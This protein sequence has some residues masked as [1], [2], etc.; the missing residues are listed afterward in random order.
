MERL[1]KRIGNSVAYSYF[2]SNHSDGC[3][4][5]MDNCLQ[6]LADYED[7]EEQGLLIELKIPFGTKIY[8]V[9]EQSTDVEEYVVIGI[10]GTRY[11]VEEPKCI[12][13]NVDYLCS[14]SDS[15]IGKT[16]FLTHSGAEEALS[17]MGKQKERYN[18]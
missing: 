13:T 9:D 3:Y 17:K 15:D 2:N 6:K 5:M 14:F 8:Y 18:E 4:E 1:T 7:K 11:V 10:V 16:V 12:E